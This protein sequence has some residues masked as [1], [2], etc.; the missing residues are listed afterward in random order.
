MAKSKVLLLSADKYHHLQNLVNCSNTAKILA[1][2]FKNELCYDIVF[3]KGF[4]IASPSLI[5]NTIEQMLLDFNENEDQFIFYYIGHGQELIRNNKKEKIYLGLPTY[6]PGKK[7]GALS[8]DFVIDILGDIKKA[9]FIIDAPVSTVNIDGYQTIS[10]EKLASSQ[11]VRIIL[12]NSS[13][14]ARNTKEV[15]SPF[16]LALERSLRRFVDLPGAYDVI[17]IANKLLNDMNL[18][19]YYESPRFFGFEKAKKTTFE[20]SNHG[21]TILYN[22]CDFIINDIYNQ[23]SGSREDGIHELASLYSQ[24]EDILLKKAAEEKLKYLLSTEPIESIR[25]TINLILRDTSVESVFNLDNLNLGQFIDK[26]K[27]IPI[28]QK[29][30]EGPFLMGINDMKYYIAAQN[31]HTV[32]LKDY[33]ITRDLVTVHDYIPY[34]YETKN[35]PPNNW[36]SQEWVIQHL[37]H[38]VS[39]VSFHDACSFCGWLTKKLQLSNEINQ[40]HFFRL[41]TEAEWEKAAR[42]IDGRIHPWGDIQDPTKC[43]IK[44]SGIMTTSPVGSFSPQGDSPYGCRDVIGNVWEWTI[45]IWGLSANRPDYFYPYSRDDGRESMKAPDNFKRIIRGGG[46]YYD[47]PCATCVVRNRANPTSFHSG[48][49]FRMVLENN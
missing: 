16:S 30:Q 31:Q 4:N 49:G 15:I 20:A 1:E 47:D 25:N 34:I 35:T 46:Y 21:G 26:R 29:V 39:C 6:L 45:S 2:T 27:K 36:V 44:A 10:Y 24:D 23:N 18:S 28:I 8:L 17:D 7:T 33:Y 14:A 41:P 40:S 3:L 13:A 12:A 22:C 9:L 38:P 32:T 19:G 48:G 43:N 5:K 37:N 42:G 11:P